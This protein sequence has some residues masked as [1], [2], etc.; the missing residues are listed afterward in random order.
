MTGSDELEII[1]ALVGPNASDFWE[2]GDRLSEYHFE[3]EPA[4]V[5]F[6]IL[7]SHWKRAQDIPSEWLLRKHLGMLQGRLGPDLHS[8]ALKGIERA[9]K[10]G[11]K[12]T[13]AFLSEFI[14]GREVANFRKETENLELGQYKE[15][16]RSLSERLD[17]LNSIG[18]HQEETPGID[19]FSH[20]FLVS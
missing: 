20:K 2:F 7:K 16:V 14:S 11:N 5:L 1:S 15:Y 18:G 10:P 17:K 9:Y 6:L 13:E 8:L 19:P 12:T 4:K 3:Y